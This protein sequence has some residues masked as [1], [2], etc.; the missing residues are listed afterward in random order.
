MVA[1]VR[2]CSVQLDVQLL[3]HVQ[4]VQHDDRTLS[5]GPNGS[6]GIPLV[7]GKHRLPITGLVD[8]ESPLHCSQ[9]ECN[10]DENDTHYY[11]CAFP[12]FIDAWRSEFGAP[13]AFFGFEL[14][15]AYINDSGKFSVRTHSRVIAPPCSSMPL[16]RRA[17]D[18]STLPPCIFLAARILALREGGTAPGAHCHR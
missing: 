3:W 12:Q 14:L 9:G 1:T 17:C 13:D 8:T 2:K 15:P 5:R 6:H 7:S 4:L 16:V 18:T 11:G 10:A